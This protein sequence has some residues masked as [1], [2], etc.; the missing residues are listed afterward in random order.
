MLDVGQNADGR[1]E[2]F[3]RGSNGALY[4][5]WQISPND[6]WSGWASLGGKIDLLAVGQ[7]AS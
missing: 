7:N 5:K 3:V 6:G 1:L 2:V 4:H